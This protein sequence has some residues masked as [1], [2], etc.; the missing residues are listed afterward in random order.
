MLTLKN[1][2]VILVFA[3]YLGHAAFALKVLSITQPLKP[4]LSQLPLPPLSQHPSLPQTQPAKQTKSCSKTHAHAQ[5]RQ[6]V[7]EM[8][9]VKHVKQVTSITNQQQHQ[10]QYVHLA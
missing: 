7:M 10:Q 6:S 1:V 3:T 2:N 8:V 5:T 9:N 4:V